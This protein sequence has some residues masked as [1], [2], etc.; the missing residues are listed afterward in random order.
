QALALARFCLAMRL[1]LETSL[2]IDQALALSLEA[3][4]NAAFA[5][6]ADAVGRALRGGSSVSE[7]LSRV[8]LFGA[9]FQA[10]V[11]V[12]EE[13]GRLPDVMRKQT[14]Y[15][16]ELAGERLTLLTRALAFAVWL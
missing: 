8:G 4:G 10:V 13:V 11:S 16:E 12:A 5:A 14:Q 15:Y 6:S 9:D 3:T 7:A 2:P 1:T